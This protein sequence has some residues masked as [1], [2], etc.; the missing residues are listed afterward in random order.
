MKVFDKTQI[1][2]PLPYAT[3]ITERNTLLQLHFPLLPTY[4]FLPSLP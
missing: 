3:L 2:N 4:S 1:T